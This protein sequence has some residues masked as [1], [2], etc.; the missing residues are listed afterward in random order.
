MGLAIKIQKPMD[1][2]NNI[3]FSFRLDCDEPLVLY[4]RDSV[5]LTRIKVSLCDMVNLRADEVKNC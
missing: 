1:I 2:S 3:T 5:L 4:I